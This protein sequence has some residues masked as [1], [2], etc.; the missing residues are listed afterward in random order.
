MPQA[1]S[2]G[3]WALARQGG[4]LWPIANWDQRYATG[5]PARADE[6]MS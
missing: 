3:T 5:L 2:H 6:L 1:N 4:Y